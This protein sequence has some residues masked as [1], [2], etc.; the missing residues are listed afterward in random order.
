MRR[1][2]SEV[3]HA[4]KA[5]AALVQVRRLDDAPQRRVTAVARAINADARRVRNLLRDEVRN[6]VG[7]VVLHCAAPLLVAR[8][9]ELAA[10][11]CRPAKL[12]L[13][14]RIAI[15][16][17]DLDREVEPDRGPAVGAAV[18]IEDQLIRRLEVRLRR[19]GRH[20]RLTRR[21]R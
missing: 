2:R 17:Q 7:D 12:R 9:L 11:A 18:G 14:D 6:S 8:L 16:C 5:H 1:H 13:E 21:S 3:A 19:A 4:G 15:C 10:E 20:R